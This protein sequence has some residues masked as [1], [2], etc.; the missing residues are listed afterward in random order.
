M[1][2]RGSRADV[3]KNLLGC[4]IFFEKKIFTSS[5]GNLILISSERGTAS[6]TRNRN[7][8][9]NRK[10]NIK[11]SWLEISQLRCA[12]LRSLYSMWRV[13]RFDRAHYNNEIREQIALLRKLRAL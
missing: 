11:L 6:E 13:R 1:R 7:R 12:I 4:E 9:R 3:K 2:P 10:M 5:Q 8:N